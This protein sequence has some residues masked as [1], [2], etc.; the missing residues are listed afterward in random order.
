MIGLVGRGRRRRIEDD[1][2][3]NER[4]RRGRCKIV[5]GDGKMGCKREEESVSW[6]GRIGPR[7]GI[8][9]NQH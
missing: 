1:D 8:G 4:K 5:T 2:N 9:S 3:D 7:R 6:C